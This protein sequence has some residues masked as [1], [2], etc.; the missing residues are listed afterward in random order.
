[1]LCD[2]SARRRALFCRS[3]DREGSVTVRRA[4]PPALIRRFRWR[5]Q[6]QAGAR[7]AS[8]ISQTERNCSISPDWTNRPEP[9]PTQSKQLGRRNSKSYTAFPPAMP[10]QPLTSKWTAEDD[11]KLR[12]LWEKPISIGSIAMRMARSRETIREKAQGLGLPPKRRPVNARQ[13]RLPF[14]ERV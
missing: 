11:A 1:M 13:F 5:D 8:L 9:L 12:R 3:H 2:R 7:A 4:S 14:R 6:P 10:R